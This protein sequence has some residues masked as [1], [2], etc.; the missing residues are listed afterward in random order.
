MTNAAK[1]V[2]LLIK[3][4]NAVEKGDFIGRP[5]VKL[6]DFLDELILKIINEDYDLKEYIDLLNR[7]KDKY[8]CLKKYITNWES[9]ASPV[10]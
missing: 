5:K 7:L 2:F 10:R 3:R 4:E 6:I 9:P 8:P 1:L